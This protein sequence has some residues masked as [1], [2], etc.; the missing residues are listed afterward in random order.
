MAGFTFTGFEGIPDFLFAGVVAN[1]SAYFNAP[2]AF[3]TPPVLHNWENGT[4]EKDSPLASGN[5]TLVEMG[6]LDFSI[7]NLTC[8]GVS[9]GKRLRISAAR[10]A[11]T[12]LAILVPL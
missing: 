8:A 6:K 9:S 12:G 10:P 4:L 3:T 5:G 7:D 1:V 2:G 11:T